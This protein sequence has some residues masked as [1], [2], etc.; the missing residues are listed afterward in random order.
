M[1]FQSGTPRATLKQKENRIIEA[2]ERRLER[3]RPRLTRDGVG[4][5]M[6]G[7]HATMGMANI[8]WLARLALRDIHRKT[9]HDG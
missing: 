7:C 1:C 8:T 5:C 4:Q 6:H 3:A 2:R 9:R